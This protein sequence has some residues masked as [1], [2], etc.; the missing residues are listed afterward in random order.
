MLPLQRF[1]KFAVLAALSSL[2]A[3]PIVAQDVPAPRGKNAAPVVHPLGS[4]DGPWL[5]RG[6][7]I[8]PDRAWTFGVLPNGVRY[9]VRRNAVPPGQVSIRVAMDV[10]SLMERPD[11]RG[12]AH[13]IE[14]LSFR[15]S[16][17]VA[18]GESKR[19]WQRLG[20]T[21]G[22]DTNAATGFTQT[23]YKL[24]LPSATPDGLD[25]SMKILSGMMMAP[26]LND[27]SLNAERPV[28]LAEQREQPGPQVRLGDAS[29][30]LFFRG[31]IMF[32]VHA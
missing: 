1:A 7:D 32:H 20:V 10:G 23:S 25:E 28:V 13:L 15:A 27:A 16:Q 14:H 24:D 12:F 31:R 26:A 22:A 19:I 29:R 8:P 11:E 2:I 17:Y 9:A 18:D 5:F 6:S 3:A 30:E 4:A 21:F